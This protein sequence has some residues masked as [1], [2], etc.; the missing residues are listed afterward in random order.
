VCDDGVGIAADKLPQVFEMFTQIDRSL[1]RSQGGL[2]IGLAL[3]KRLVEL[4]GG[5]VS[6]ASAGPGRGS[7]FQVRLPIS[8]ATAAAIPQIPQEQEVAMDDSS[9][10]SVR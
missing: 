8:A 2:G 5:S 9:T 1:V 10:K 4:H 7:A 3:V 6:A